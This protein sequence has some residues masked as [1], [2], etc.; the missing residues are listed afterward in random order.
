MGIGIAAVFFL[1]KRTS[2]VINYLIV[3]ILVSLGTVMLAFVIS[4]QCI[5]KI[6]QIHIV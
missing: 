5:A 1:N 6:H 2:A 4:G 3:S